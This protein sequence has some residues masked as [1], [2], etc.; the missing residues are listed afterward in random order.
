MPGCRKRAWQRQWCLGIH[1]TRA[2]RSRSVRQPRSRAKAITRR[3]PL[4]Q[5]PRFP[6]LDHLAHWSSSRSCIDERMASFSG[7]SRFEAG[8]VAGHHVRAIRA[9]GAAAVH[10]RRPRGTRGRAQREHGRRR[11]QRDAGRRDGRH[12][13]RRGTCGS[14]RRQN[15]P[16][17]CVVVGAR[18]RPHTRPVIRLHSAPS[19]RRRSL[20]MDAPRRRTTATQAVV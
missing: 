20:T 17:N 5:T 3:W 6:L 2:R 7:I 12:V 15:I 13:E 4:C 10:A 8:T 1:R 9:L 19:G 16:S 14:R 11:A 18:S